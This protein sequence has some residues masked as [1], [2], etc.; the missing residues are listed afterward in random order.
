MSVP[1]KKQRFV[2]ISN[3]RAWDILV[4]ELVRDGISSDKDKL[5]WHE[6]C[7]CGGKILCLCDK[8]GKESCRV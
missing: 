5:E 7:A 4:R 1:V 2:P 8:C 3:R 6:G